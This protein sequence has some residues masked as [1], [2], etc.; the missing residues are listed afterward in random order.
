VT[1]DH[2]TLRVRTAAFRMDEERLL[3][4]AHKTLLE[5]EGSCVVLRPIRPRFRIVRKA[6]IR[7]F[8]TAVRGGS[9][10]KEPAALQDPDR[11]RIGGSFPGFVPT[12]WFPVVNLN[13]P[14]ACFSNAHV[15]DGVRFPTCTW[16]VATNADVH[17]G[18]RR[19]VSSVSSRCVR[20]GLGS[21]RLGSRA[22]DRT[23][24]DL[25]C[26]CAFPLVGQDLPSHLLSLLLRLP[27]ACTRLSSFRFGF[28]ISQ[29]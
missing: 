26:A 18:G 2:P 20:G 23:V 3:P 4:P 29:G 13:T 12:Y 8:D 10:G 5:W 24:V 7:P 25:P 11:H 19:A 6:R 22:V 27:C 17:R 9:L 1:I 14:R 16:S 21:F 15:R 28:R